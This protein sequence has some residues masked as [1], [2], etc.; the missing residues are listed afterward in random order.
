MT[1]VAT[2]KKKKKNYKKSSKKTP[3]NKDDD[4]TE[5]Q[6]CGEDYSSTNVLSEAL[7]S[8]ATK[9]FKSG[10]LIRLSLGPH[11]FLYGPTFWCKG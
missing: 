5:E 7:T 6:D 10:F 2:T 11:H 3:C 8:A 1:T 9:G 4:V